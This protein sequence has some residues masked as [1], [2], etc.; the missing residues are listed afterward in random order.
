M[1][2]Q[3]N[4]IETIIRQTEDVKSLMREINGFP[5]NQKAPIRMLEVLKERCLELAKSIQKYKIEANG[6]KNTMDTLTEVSEK[7]NS[8]LIK[9]PKDESELYKEFG[10]TD[11][12]YK[13]LLAWHSV[14]GNSNEAIDFTSAFKEYIAI[15]E[16]G[17][18]EPKEGWDKLIPAATGLISIAG[19]IV[20]FHG[21]GDVH[22]LYY[23]TSSGILSIAG[24][25]KSVMRRLRRFFKK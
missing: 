2:D 16:N 6:G 7:N 20:A 10:F 18:E 24:A 4:L 15:L 8:A 1:A 25:F 17:K 12:E 3:N 14:M 11:Q 5:K 22:T 21:S 23:S 9:S 19:D 13:D